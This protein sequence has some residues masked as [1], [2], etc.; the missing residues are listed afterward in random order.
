VSRIVGRLAEGTLVTTPRHQVDVVITEYGAAELAGLTVEERERAL[1][2]VAH[3]DFRAE[4]L[5]SLDP[6]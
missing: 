1:A 3:P 2:E 4:L 5:R 6:A